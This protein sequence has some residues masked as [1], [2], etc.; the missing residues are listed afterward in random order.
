MI[1][2][3]L[4]CKRCC[5]Q[6][7]KTGSGRRGRSIEPRNQANN[8][9]FRSNLKGGGLWGVLERGKKTWTA[10]AADGGKEGNDLSMC[11]NDLAIAEIE[12]F[13]YLE[14]KWKAG[15]EEKDVR[16]KGGASG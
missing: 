1:T 10:S 4:E 16:R 13:K 9:G 3:Q 11:G 8:L 12:E 5:G 2:K 6:V 7:G 15:S 14:G